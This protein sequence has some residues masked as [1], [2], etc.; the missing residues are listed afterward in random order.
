MIAAPIIQYPETNW[1]A[2]GPDTYRTSDTVVMI[3][4]TVPVVPADID[5]ETIYTVQHRFAIERVGVTGAYTDWSDDGM[6]VGITTLTATEIPW[7]FDGEFVVEPQVGDTVH[8]EFKTVTR[9][10]ILQMI[11]PVI[12]QSVASLVAVVIVDE[13]D[14]SATADLPTSVQ[15]KR[16]REYIKILVPAE[17]I[18][19]NQDNDF[20]G[21][22]FY[23]SL[24]AGAGYVRMNDVLIT[25][26]DESE[27]TSEVLSVSNYNETV[28]DLTV[29]TTKSHTVEHRFYT[30][31]LTTTVL[32]KLITENKIPNIFLADGQT[33][34]MGQRFYFVTTAVAFDKVLNEAEES[35]Y[36]VELAGSFLEYT[37]NYRSLPTRSRNDVLFSMSRDMMANNKTVNVVAG[38]VIRDIMDPISLEFERFYVIQ[39]FIFAT[40]SLDTLVKYDDADGDGLSDPPAS[41][42]TKRRLASA[43]GVRD[44]VTLQLLIDEQFD[45]HAANFDMLRHENV[46]SVGTATVYVTT[47]PQNDILVA[48]GTSLSYPGDITR[49]IAAVAFL[50][51]GTYIM[52]AGNLDYYFNPSLQRWEMTVNIEARLP[53]AAGNVPARSITRVD[54]ASS[55][56]QVI[57]T[58]PTLYGSDRESNQELANRVKLARASFDSGT[59]P[60]YASSAYDVPGVLQARVE[61]EGDPLMMRDYDEPTMKHIGGKVDIYLKGSRLAQ[62]V[63]QVAFK[64]EYP[65]DTYG[66]NVGEQFDVSDA[67]SFRL[68]AR[69][70]KVTVSS[71]IVIVHRVRNVTRGQDYNLTGM[72]LTAD[73]NTIILASSFE[74]QVIGLATLDV[75][76]V[77]YRYRS[78]NLL[79]LSNQ[80]VVSIEQVTDS[81]GTVID[82]SKYRLMKV[83]DPLTVGNSNIA[84]DAIQ[85]LFQDNDNIAEFVT[86]TD[87][88][89]DMLL[90]TD[91]RLLYKGVDSATISVANQSDPTEIYLKDVDYSI[92]HGDEVE[93]TYLKLLTNGKIRHG[94][95]VNVS[96]EAAVNFNVTYTVNTIIGQV[97]AN[98]VT[99]R[100]ACADVAVKQAVENQLDMAFKIVRKTGV[101]RT[102][103]KSRVQ[104]S[105]ANFVRRLNMG[106]TLTQDDVINVVRGVDGVKSVQMPLTRLMKRNGSFIAL[107]DIGSPAFEIYQR[108]GGAGVTSYR[109]VLPVLTYSTVANGGPDNLFR[110]IYEDNRTLTL[111]S[112]AS[113]VGRGRGRGY[114]QDDGKIIVSTT[115]GRPPQEK[116]YRVSYFAYYTAD[117][118]VVSDVETSQMEY[119]AIDAVSTK[120]IEIV[121]DRIIKRGL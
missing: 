75:M 52:D 38:S 58:D 13:D 92:V 102:L 42:I 118:N 81:T 19:L 23:M 43:L 116:D 78:S 57:N 67:L 35:P 113:L 114:I 77:D 40:L 18:I 22:N 61:K 79:V 107:D 2:G 76:E 20:A 26:P 82:T 49:G 108:T 110:G 41:S 70:P 30:F 74:N 88:P 119:L 56:L 37:T 120:N 1:Q 15:M 11:G 28:G 103:L 14:I 55:L 104:R 36:S 73:G 90:S 21:C 95:R 121:D 80:P 34:N 100:H 48:D 24:Q 16:A 64:Y 99:L 25:D 3:S 86:I 5:D 85:F 10:R 7:S 9:R 91:A 66:N 53:G 111:V 84:K 68:R 59:E 27:T 51:R 105:L 54:N 46:K 45:K 62:V 101:D 12:D 39:D 97:A 112:D 83:E 63:D 6:S 72:Q 31:E 8:M 115:D 4:G 50:V 96:Y 17:A 106:E 71:P 29:D 32:T 94:D 89:H 44:E 117:E 69:N 65:T 98:V 109:T 60:G 87:E 47:A 33:L 93:Y